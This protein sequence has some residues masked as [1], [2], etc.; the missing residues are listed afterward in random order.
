LSDPGDAVRRSI[1][2]AD[3]TPLIRLGLAGWTLTAIA[4]STLRGKTHAHA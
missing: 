1:V 3:L 2:L 4:W